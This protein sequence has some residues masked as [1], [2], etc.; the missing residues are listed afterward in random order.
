LLS[1]AVGSNAVPDLQ[2]SNV[3]GSPVP[4]YLVGAKVLKVFPFGPVPG[5]AAMI[6]VHSYVRTCYVG[7]NL[8][9]DAI[10]E[11]ELFLECLRDGVEEVLALRP[12][13][14]RRQRSG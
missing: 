1:S 9:A 12:R 8:D 14:A 4:L 10:T 2:V 5:P 13:P 3:P 7:I 11:P 6:T